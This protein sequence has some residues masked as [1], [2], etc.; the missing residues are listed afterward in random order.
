[1]REAGSTLA[2]D[3][4]RREVKVGGVGCV[5]G[6]GLLALERRLGFEG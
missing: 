3:M 6:R 5:G 4:S 1:M 2:A